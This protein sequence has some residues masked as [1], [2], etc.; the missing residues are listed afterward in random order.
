LLGFHFM[1]NFRQPYLADSLQDFWRR[2]H[3][4][5]STWLRDYLYIP[6]GGNRLGSGRTYINLMITMLLGGLW[7]GANWTFVIWGGIHGAWLSVERM[8]TRGGAKLG[9]PVRCVALAVVALSWIFFRA[10][11]VHAAVHMLASLRHFEWQAQYAPQLAFLAMVSGIMLLVDLRLERCHE[12]YL[13]ER[14]SLTWPIGAAAAMAILMVAY[15][16]SETSAFIYFQ[17]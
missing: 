9:W 14:W 15:A 13:F 2:W 5:L 11:S 3:I 4:S 17:F 7:H 8:L 16:A 12:E 6:L 10:R 1:L